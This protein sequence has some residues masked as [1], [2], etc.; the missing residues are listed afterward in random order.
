MAGFP[1]PLGLFPG[2]AATNRPTVAT[3]EPTVGKTDDTAAIKKAVAAGKAWAIIYFRP[4]TYL[5]SSTI[6]TFYGTQFIG[7][8]NNRPVI[9]AAASFIGLGVISTDHYVEN[10]GTGS[11]GNAKQW[12]INTANF[13]RQIRNFVIDITATDQGAYVAALHYQVAQATSLQF[14]GRV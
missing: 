12:F 13:Y 3:S 8:A 6:E 1:Y 5:V 2:D 11:D 9:K 10:G 4:G 7:D 14:V